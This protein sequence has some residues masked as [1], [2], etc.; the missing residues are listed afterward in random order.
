M[1]DKVSKLLI[2]KAWQLTAQG[3]WE[4]SDKI[5]KFLLK[6]ATNRIDAINEKIQEIDRR[7]KGE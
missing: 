6:E 5:S 1:T 4:I 7:I 2:A 3:K